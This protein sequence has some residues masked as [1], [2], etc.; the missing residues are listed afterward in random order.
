MLSNDKDQAL[1]A[2]TV[3]QARMLRVLVKSVATKA[4]HEVTLHGDHFV[5]SDDVVYGLDALSRNVSGLPVKD[6]TEAVERHVS[7]LRAAMK[8]PDEFDVPTE[9][10]LS[11]TYLRLYEN[12]ALPDVDWL[13]YGREAFPGVT[14]LLALDLPETVALYNDDRVRRHG[15]DVLREAGLRN[16]RA[17]V[18]DHRTEIDGVQVLAGSVYVASTALVLDEVV[19]RTTGERELPNGVLVAMPFRNQLLYH[20]PRDQGFVESLNAMAG[21][22]ISGHSTEAG[23]LSPHVHWW[24]KGEFQQLTRHDEAEGS[25]EIHVDGGFADMFRRLMPD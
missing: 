14:E 5:D 2:L 6:W 8:G 13:G 25:I 16:L 24:N 4:G 20:V 22:A 7:T 19:Q 3:N 10:L 21:M 17:V 1:P 11:R 9:D 23:P 12:A 15:L 18:P